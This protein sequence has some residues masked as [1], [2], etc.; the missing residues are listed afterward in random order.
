MINRSE[1]FW[2]FGV[3]IG[4]FGGIAFM[5]HTTFEGIMSFW[6]AGIVTLVIAL[7]IQEVR[8]APIRKKA[9]ENKE[10]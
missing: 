6:G 5:M 2:L 1:L 4:F 7:I 8:L 10:S 3:A 9:S